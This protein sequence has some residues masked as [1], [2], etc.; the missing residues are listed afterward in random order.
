MLTARPGFIT[1]S[2]HLPCPTQ[3]ENVL[4]QKQQQVPLC[5]CQSDKTE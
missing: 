3:L 1:S 4:T 2:S 5:V